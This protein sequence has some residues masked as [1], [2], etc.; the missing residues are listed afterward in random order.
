[1]VSWAFNAFQQRKAKNNCKEEF[2]VFGYA[3]RSEIIQFFHMGIW[4]AEFTEGTRGWDYPWCL[5]YGAVNGEGLRVLD[6]GCGASKFPLILARMGHETHG[7]DLEDSARDYAFGLNRQLAID[8]KVPVHYHI[9]NI[10]KTHFPDAFFDRIFCISVIEH[11]DN[12]R[13]MGNVL[14]EFKRLLK[15]AGMA[16]VTVDVVRY[17]VG[18]FQEGWDYRPYVLGS[19]MRPLHPTMPMPTIQHMDTDPDTYW[20]QVGFGQDYSSVGMVLI[21]EI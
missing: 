19:G 2:G 10:E 20:T 15:P 1:M 21:K 13:A 8:Y 9:G 4:G 7:I 14:A 12:G 18:T 16:I 5:Y 6:A 11:M 3:R 17:P